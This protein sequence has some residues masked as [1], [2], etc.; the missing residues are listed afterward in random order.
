MEEEPRPSGEA[1][2]SAE[3]FDRLAQAGEVLVGAYL[4]ELRR[5]EFV[6]KLRAVAFIEGKKRFFQKRAI[7]RRDA[8]T[9]RDY[10]RRH[11]TLILELPQLAALLDSEVLVFIE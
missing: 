11:G 2:L 10:V 4:D 7:C 3:E 6:P 1:L 9:H 8:R 5:E